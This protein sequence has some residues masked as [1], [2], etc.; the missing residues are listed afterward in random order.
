MFLSIL[1]FIFLCGVL[2]LFPHANPHLQVFS[3][4]FFHPVTSASINLPDHDILSAS[5]AQF[6]LIICSLPPSSW[7]S[8]S[9][10]IHPSVSLFNPFLFKHFTHLYTSLHLLWSVI[11]QQPPP[12]SIF[13]PSSGTKEVYRSLDKAFLRASWHPNSCW[14]HFF[15]ISL[16]WKET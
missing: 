16:R 15:F 10:F 6:V 5:S 1:W 9:V 13:L 11:H 8:R 12:L 3:S 7:S 4:T 14:D 2:V